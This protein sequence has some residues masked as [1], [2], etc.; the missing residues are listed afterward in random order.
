MCS[1]LNIKH[2]AV[3]LLLY[4]LC[5]LLSVIKLF[6]ILPEGWTRFS[7]WSL[8]LSVRSD[9][10]L[11]LQMLHRHLSGCSARC[12]Y[13][14][15]FLRWNVGITQGRRF[16]GPARRYGGSSAREDVRED[17]REPPPATAAAAALA[18]AE[19]PRCAQRHRYL[20]G[21]GEGKG[22]PL[23]AVLWPLRNGC[24]SMLWAFVLNRQAKL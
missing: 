11:Y 13:E 2:P 9:W 12:F 5:L 20:P 14:V 10:N 21:R 17:A 22:H 4:Y 6:L 7:H 15:W 23:P 3:N 8:C 18:A 24:V 19:R 1:W 16:P